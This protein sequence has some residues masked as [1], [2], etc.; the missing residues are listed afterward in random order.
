M[1]EGG[2]QKKKI[3]ITFKI[4]I[5]IKQTSPKLNKCKKNTQKEKKAYHQ[6]IPKNY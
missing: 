2:G 3:I 5:T 4:F 6:Q 1:M